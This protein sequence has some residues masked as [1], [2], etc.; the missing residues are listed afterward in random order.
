M[1]SLFDARDASLPLP[2]IPHR[3]TFVSPTPMLCSWIQAGACVFVPGAFHSNLVCGLDAPAR[4]EA[5]LCSS[6]RPCCR[7]PTPGSTFVICACAPASVIFCSLL[8]GLCKCTGMEAVVSVFSQVPDDTRV[9]PL[10]YC[11]RARAMWQPQRD[12]IAPATIPRPA[13]CPCLPFVRINLVVGGKKFAFAHEF[14]LQPHILPQTC[15]QVCWLLRCGYISAFLQGGHQR[16]ELAV[17]VRVRLVCAHSLWVLCTD[18]YVF[19]LHLS[20]SLTSVDVNAPLGCGCRRFVAATHRDLACVTCGT[21]MDAPLC[22][23]YQSENGL[24]CFKFW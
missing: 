16:L 22:G 2:S 20:P 19:G 4:G 11:C 9:V 18:L 24:Y 23:G 3:W 1:G 17:G 12:G 7:L 14:T 13:V 6:S 8:P 10:G 21:A 5:S 15:L